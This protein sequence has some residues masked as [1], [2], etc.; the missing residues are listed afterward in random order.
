LKKSHKLFFF[1]S[2]PQIPA[3]LRF[4]HNYSELKHPTDFKP[5]Q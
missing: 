1:N 5:L 3:K 2:I 4:N